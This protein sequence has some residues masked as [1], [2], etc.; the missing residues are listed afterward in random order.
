MDTSA[1]RP[2][3]HLGPE[4]VAKAKALVTGFVGRR[5]NDE[6]VANVAAALAEAGISSGRF[7]SIRNP[8]CGTT[9]VEFE[10]II[11]RRV[12]VSVESGPTV[13]VRTE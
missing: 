4:I 2:P 3:S 9:A 5:V 12:T 1:P 10:D 7:F 8:W 11:N 13:T 6:L